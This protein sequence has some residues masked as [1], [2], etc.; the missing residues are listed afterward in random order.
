MIHSDF[1]DYNWFDEFDNDVSPGD[2]FDEWKCMNDTGTL[3]G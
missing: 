1:E 3:G 2:A